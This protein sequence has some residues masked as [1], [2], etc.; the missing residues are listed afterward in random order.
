VNH[1]FDFQP[2][3]GDQ[4]AFVNGADEPKTGLG[5]TWASRQ[6]LA[7]LPQNSEIAT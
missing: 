4:L 3:G 7:R 6:A 5:Y 1:F 2:C